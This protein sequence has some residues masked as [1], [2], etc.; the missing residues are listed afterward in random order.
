MESDLDDE[1]NNMAERQKTKEH[2]IPTLSETARKVASP[3]KIKLDKI[4][5]IAYKMIACTL[6]LG[7]VNGGNN[8]IITLYSCLGQ[9]MG[10]TS[11]QEIK[12]VVRRFKVRDGQIQLIMF[13]TGPAG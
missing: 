2:K 3:E 1:M 9:T 7:L 8:P 12:N 6:F 4:Q 5:Y 11:T 10:G 13:L